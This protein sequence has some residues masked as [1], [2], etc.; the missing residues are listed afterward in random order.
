[1]ACVDGIPI[2]IVLDELDAFLGSSASLL[3]TQE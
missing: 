1:M 2:L 3:D